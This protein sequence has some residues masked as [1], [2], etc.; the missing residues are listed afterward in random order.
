VGGVLVS[1]RAEVTSDLEVRSC[2]WCPAGIAGVLD[3]YNRTISSVQLAGPTLFTPVLQFACAT[4]ASAMVSQHQQ[5]YFVLL[6][7]TDG[8]RSPPPADPSRSRSR[9]PP[10]LMLLVWSSL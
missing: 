9:R 5:K 6:I 10:V 1:L 8:R 4:A 3:A 7:I 2:W